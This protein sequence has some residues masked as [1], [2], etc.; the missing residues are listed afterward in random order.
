MF[1]YIDFPSFN[2]ALPGDAVPLDQSGDDC[3]CKAVWGDR[4]NSLVAVQLV[5]PHNIF[6]YFINIYVLIVCFL[7]LHSAVLKPDFNLPLCQMKSFRDLCSLWSRN[8]RC[9]EVFLLQ[10]AD[11]FL[12]IRLPFL[13][14]PQRRWSR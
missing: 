4:P 13:P 3:S 6:L 5:S 9:V 7:L 8:V 12:R 14:R 1:L 10:V 11:L 2:D